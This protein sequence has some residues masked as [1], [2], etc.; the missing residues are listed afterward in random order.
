MRHAH[1]VHM[2]SDEG[3]LG[4]CVTRAMCHDRSMRL[5]PSLCQYLPASYIYSSRQVPKR[6][7]FAHILNRFPVLT[8]P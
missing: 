1:C 8:P 5:P 2:A 7:R 4:A 3:G 6:T